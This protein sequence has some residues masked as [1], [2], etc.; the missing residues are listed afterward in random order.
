MEESAAITSRRAIY[1]ALA[2]HRADARV[3]ASPGSSAWT[4]V[5]EHEVRFSVFAV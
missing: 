4:V 5:F 2:A 1:E 3:W